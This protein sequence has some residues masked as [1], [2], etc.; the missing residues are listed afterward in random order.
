[1]NLSETQWKIIEALSD[2][3]KTP[4]ELAGKLKISLP[5]MHAQLA[6]LKQYNLIKET[7]KIAGKTRPYSKYSLKD[8][9]I[10][11]VKALPNDTDKIFLEA[12]SY[13]NVHLNIWSI[14]QKEYHY[15]IE[16]LWWELEPLSIDAFA[17]FGSVAKGTAKEGSDIDILI[18]SD[19]NLG[20]LQKYNAKLI[21]KPGEEKMAMVQAFAPS[22][23]EKSLNSCSK[24]A[25]E[26]VKGMRII[27]DPLNLLKRLKLEPKTKAG[28]KHEQ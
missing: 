19:K 6:K 1:M 10:Y 12:N 3:D 9:F 17:V 20:R 21:G 25:N 7:D 2:G 15:F 11:F 16:K 23:F 27:Y 5:G 26:A 24:F 4:T 28:K 22:E 13:I 14:P 8:G 18:L